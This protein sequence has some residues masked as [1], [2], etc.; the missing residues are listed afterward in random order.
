MYVEVSW[1]DTLLQQDSL[2]HHDKIHHEPYCVCWE[3]LEN[4]ELYNVT[5]AENIFNCTKQ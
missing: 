5:M 4:I 3:Y 1:F 2:A